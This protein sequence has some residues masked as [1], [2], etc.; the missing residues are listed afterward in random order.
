MNKIDYL[1]RNKGFFQKVFSAISIV[2]VLLVIGLFV[3]FFYIMS[4]TYGNAGL[5]GW[6]DDLD[7]EWYWIS[8]DGTRILRRDADIPD[9]KPQQYETRLP[10][11]LPDDAMI[12]FN[13]GS[14][15]TVYIDGELRLRYDEDDNFFPGGAVKNMILPIN[16]R[17]SDAGKIMRI[18]RNDKYGKSGLPGLYYGN[19][20]GIYTELMEKNRS[21]M[22]IAFAIASLAVV[23]IVMCI[24]VRKRLKHN[25]AIA[26]LSIGVLAISFWL[27]LNNFAFQYMFNTRYV[28]GIFAY[29]V[30]MVMCF[31]FMY[32][33][34]AVQEN[35]YAPV[36]TFGALMQ[37]ATFFVTSMLHF[38]NMKDFTRTMLP[39]NLIQL[40]ILIIMATT[41]L[42]DIKKKRSGE[43]KYVNIGLLSLCAASV[44]ELVNDN[45]FEILFNG[46]FL[47]LGLVTLLI[48]VYIYEIRRMRDASVQAQSATRSS[49]L[50]SAFLA[51]MSHEIRTPINAIVGMNE[52]ILRESANEA[53][54]DYANC[55]KIASNNL[56]YIINDIL[57]F[58]KIEAGKL[59]LVENEYNL[60][61]LI[62]GVVGS[63]KDRA[64]RKGLELNVDMDAS[65]P[66]I[67][68]GDA[69]RVYQIMVNILSNAV[70]YTEEGRVDFKV[71]GEAYLERFILRF[72]V[73][74]TGIGIK[75]E[76]KRKIFSKFERFD[77]KRN[78]GIE[79][80]GLGLAI[81]SELVSMMAGDIVVSSEYG[82]GSL[83]SVS[84]VQKIVNETPVGVFETDKFFIHK[85]EE[86]YSAGFEA[87]DAKILI[88]D[89]NGMNIRV[90]TA[91]L[92]R[93]K[94]N[95]DT[96][97][98]GKVMLEKVKDNRYDIILLDHMMPEMDGIETL[99]KFRNTRN[100]SEG[101]VVIAMTANAIKGAKE[102]YINVGFDDYI[103]KPVNGVELEKTIMQYLPS[104][105]LHTALQTEVRTKEEDKITDD[106]CELPLMDE[107]DYRYARQ[108]NGSD[109]IIAMVIRELYKFL[110]QTKDRLNSCMDIIDTEDG[111]KAYI[112][113]V[114]SLKSSAGSAGALLLSKL[115]RILENYGKNGDVAH[116]RTLHD[117]LIEEIDKHYERI[118]KAGFVSEAVQKL[119]DNKKVMAELVKLKEHL[120]NH[121]YSS[122]DGIVTELSK[123][124]YP[125]ELSADICIVTDLLDEFEY[126]DALAA[127]KKIV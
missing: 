67:L 44:I 87:P 88:V 117:V 107:F 72:D 118:G 50:K 37:L 97:M 95:I 69:T 43:F 113:E 42:I 39:M 127:L 114:H 21:G 9:D 12:G 101:A 98:S 63:L 24:C 61:E 3:L 105:L 100:K 19:S 6:H 115:A 65:M 31:P 119:N 75:E 51:N 5:R 76:D 96:C 16:L 102:Q 28:D 71:Y 10:D 111:L 126:E 99:E 58:S 68:Y 109:D 52:M 46:F 90:A 48:A 78:T 36:Y 26:V 77:E 7:C 110:P 124:D 59:E 49:E 122:I 91:L 84:I 112:L 92:K 14:Y 106:I 38:R 62:I 83:F 120:E 64:E 79:G 17:S 70:K 53:V 125:K 25:G 30:T 80:S 55:V 2:F 57:D 116:I 34:N 47:E 8:E 32:Y 85:C 4:S 40:V 86:N 73:R 11:I 54:R 121:H 123:Y 60:K 20:Y 66:S 22:F 13:T 45:F 81:T 15:T 29:F 104:H 108:L 56:L 18:V 35:R 27:I 74:D 82:K 41:I 89:D 1:N 23:S 33:L 103:S 93:T 94:M